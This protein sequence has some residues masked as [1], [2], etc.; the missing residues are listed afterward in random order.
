MPSHIDTESGSHVGESYTDYQ[1]QHIKHATT[2]TNAATEEDVRQFEITERGLDNDEIAE[3]AAYRY[4]MTI[5]LESGATDAATLTG[6]GE[7]GFNLSGD[8]FLLGGPGLIRDTDE[9]GQL[10]AVR[11]ATGPSFADD[12][13]GNGGAAPGKL[14]DSGLVPLMEV[15]GGGPVL[16]VNDDVTSRIEAATTGVASVRVEARASL[17][18]LVDTI[19]QA[20]QQFG[21]P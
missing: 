21:R 10:E 15:L 16:D 19:E 5:E 6:E 9:V 1:V 20:R 2:A 14:Y 17:Y 18:W 4:Q 7:F 11:D 8:E 3:L 13:N 12:S